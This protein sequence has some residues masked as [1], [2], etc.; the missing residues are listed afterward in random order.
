[1]DVLQFINNSE[2]YSRLLE[3]VQHPASQNIY[4]ETRLPKKNN[5]DGE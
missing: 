2:K 4:L 3:N 1:M 5:N